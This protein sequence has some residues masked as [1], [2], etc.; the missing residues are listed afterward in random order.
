MMRDLDM[1]TEPQ[2]KKQIIEIKDGKYSDGT[3][4]DQIHYLECKLILKP[5]RFESAKGFQDYAALVREAAA[6]SDVKVDASSAA[7]ARPVMREVA[8]LDTEDFRLYNNAF[9][10]RRRVSYEDYFPV[11]DPEIV[12][13]YRHPEVQSAVALDVRPTIAGDYRI[14]FKVEALPLKDQVGSYRTLFSHNTQFG[15]S[16][17]PEGDRTSMSFLAQLFPALQ[18][19]QTSPDDRVELVNQTV[20]EELLQELGV[21]DF[22]RGVS[23]KCN[24][25]LWRTRAEHEPLCAEFAYQAKFKR[26]DELGEKAL[27]RCKK[28]FL[29]LQQ[30]GRDWLALGTTKTG[31]VY[32]LKGNPPQA[33]E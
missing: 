24:V 20:V 5:D 13:K 23:A 7:G 19:L 28:F 33:H 1:P 21:L 3:L 32:R 4:F 11:G 14:K 16:Q 10:L 8:F 12:F 29:T 18:Q 6:Q 30:I 31:I 17:M 26:R 22:G 25:A 27:D 15:Q 9:I 2:P